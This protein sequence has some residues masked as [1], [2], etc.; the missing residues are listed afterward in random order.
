MF[1]DEQDHGDFRIYA[2]AIEG[3]PGQFRSAVAVQRVRGADT[4]PVVAF[5]ND[6]VGKREWESSE[7]ALKMAIKWAQQELDHRQQVPAPTSTSRS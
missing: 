5:R 7:L 1:I 2:A 6:F 3:A 4:P